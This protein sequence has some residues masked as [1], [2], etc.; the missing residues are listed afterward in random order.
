MSKVY[1]EYTFA[2]TEAISE[3][4][5]YSDM[6]F[7]RKVCRWF[8]STFHMPLNEVMN[9]DKI[10]WDSVLLHYY[11]SNLE[12]V[13]YNQI[14]DIACE[15]YLPELA[16]QNERE[17]QEIADSYII[18]QKR[19]LNVKNKKVVEKVVEKK[20]EQ[21]RMK[22]SPINMIFEDEEV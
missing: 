13:N 18:E 6:G 2:Q 5:E 10:T 3:A 7:F 1:T 22:V 12:K 21:D 17:N 20:P 15:E 14:Y 11:E 16:E 4:L 8:S 19:T 9:G